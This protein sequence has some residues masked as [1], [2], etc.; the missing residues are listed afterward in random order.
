MGQAQ[1]FMEEQF[2]ESVFHDT[3]PQ[4]RIKLAEGAV[5]PTKANPTDSG[6]DITAIGLR[7]DEE[8]GFLEYKTG[9]YLNI[10]DGYEVKIYPRSSISKYDLFLC[11]SVG[12]IDQSYNKEL[13][14]RFKTTFDYEIGYLDRDN[15]LVCKKEG[16]STVIYPKIYR[17][18]DK[19]GQ[20]IMEKRV[21]Y[22]IKQVDSIEDSGRSG[23]GS[24]TMNQDNHRTFPVT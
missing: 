6:Y 9:V 4:L 10:P 8:N 22:T 17:V 2:K 14:F 5:L 7:Y 21:E 18:G 23:F 20:M 11:N 12:V 19:I 16:I 15:D 24:T 13:L 1:Y 3:I